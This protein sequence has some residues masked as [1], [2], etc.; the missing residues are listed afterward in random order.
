MSGK[1]RADPRPDVQRALEKVLA[2]EHAS[3]SRDVEAIVMQNSIDCQW[4][5]RAEFLWGREQIR[6]CIERQW[7]GQTERRVITELWS[8]D[9]DRIALRFVAEFRNDSGVWC[10]A[11]GGETWELNSGGQVRRRFT[12]VNEHLIQEHERLL[13]WRL[14]PRPTDHPTLSEL[15]L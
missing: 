5:N 12:S 11:H 14:G 7:R 8:A 2:A 15:S 3:N 1:T 13:R 10:R 9:G 4:R 6:A